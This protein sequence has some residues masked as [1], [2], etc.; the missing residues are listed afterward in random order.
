MRVAQAQSL[1]QIGRGD[2]HKSFF[3]RRAK[4]IVRAQW[5]RAGAVGAAP[6]N[7]YSLA[8]SYKVVSSTTNSSW[9]TTASGTWASLVVLFSGANTIPNGPG[10][11]SLSPDQGPVSTTSVTISGVNFGSTQGSSTVT[12]RG[13]TATA[14][15]W[16]ATS[17]T[18]TVP[19]SATTGDV[20]VT[21][22]GVPTGDGHTFTVTSTS[23]GPAITG[24]TPTQGPVGTS[25]TITG[26]NFGSSGSVQFAG[27]SASTSGWTSTSITASVPT[28]AATGDIVV[29]VSSVNSNGADFTVTGSGGSTT[30]DIYYYFGDA[31]GSTRVI[32]T[33]DG[34]V[35]YDADSYPYGGERA[36]ADSCDPNYEFTGKERDARSALITLALGTTRPNMGAS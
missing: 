4:Y 10:I 30:S 26:N 11:S 6:F 16:S 24:V 15:S 27:V 14:T 25:V 19:S 2:T 35:C 13:V 31:L 12:F 8:S 32:T 36:Y 34:T 29:N 28:G 7:G 18:A 1:G 23:S 17:I 9:T 5:S 21:V 3:M 20:V 33:K 22:S